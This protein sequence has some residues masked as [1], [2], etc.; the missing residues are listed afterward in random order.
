[1]SGRPGFDSRSSQTKDFKL[2]VEDPLSNALHI[3]CSSTQKLVD[4]LPE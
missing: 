2:V 1:M 4:P 3:K